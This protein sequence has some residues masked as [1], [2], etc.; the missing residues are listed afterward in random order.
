MTRLVRTRM[1]AVRLR[2]RGLRGTA[3]HQD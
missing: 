2:M 1:A 3:V